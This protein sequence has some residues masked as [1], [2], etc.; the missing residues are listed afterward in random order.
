MPSPPLHDPIAAF[1]PLAPDLFDDN[2]GER[3][4]VY[5]VRDGDDRFIDHGHGRH[6][7]GDKIGQCGR[8]IVKMLNKGTPGVRIP[9]TLNIPAFWHFIDI[10]LSAAETNKLNQH[11]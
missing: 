5:I 7:S 2:D 9:R 11:N 4:A 6:E 8:T 10:A 1:V 3:F